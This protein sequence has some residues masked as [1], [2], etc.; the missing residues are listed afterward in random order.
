MGI[1]VFE[2]KLFKK[3][4]DFYEAHQFLLIPELRQFRRVTPTG[5]DNV[6]FSFSSY[7]EEVWLDVNFGNR[8]EAIEHIAQQF[9]TNRLDFRPEANT[10]LTTIGRFRQRSYFRYKFRTPQDLDE[11]SADITEFFS[12]KG[13]AFFDLVRTLPDVDATIN[14]FP[15]QRCPY[16]IN[17]VH[18]C[19]KGLVTASLAE[20]PHLEHLYGTYDE[21]LRTKMTDQQTLTSFARLYTFLKYYSSN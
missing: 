10:L 21:Q 12:I 19:F 17:P 3:L 13:F 1:H 6:I 14:E 7:G 20:S 8:I 9:L 15:Q 5:F 4:Y 16:I 11:I 2:A 18:R